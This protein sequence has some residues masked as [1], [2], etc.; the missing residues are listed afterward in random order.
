LFSVDAGETGDYQV[1]QV[2][3][4]SKTSD[5]HA[6][7][8]ISFERINPK[9]GFDISVYTH[10]E[11]QPAGKGGFARQPG[12]QPKY[13][14]QSVLE[15]MNEFEQACAN[16]FEQ[17]LADEIKQAYDEMHHKQRNK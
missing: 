2:N 12:T 4:M 1:N 6:V 16:M 9:T 17:F 3:T 5:L 14:E 15:L 11:L 7:F 13:L 8:S 10:E